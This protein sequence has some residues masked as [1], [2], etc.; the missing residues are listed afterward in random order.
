MVLRARAEEPTPS[1]RQGPFTAVFGGQLIAGRNVETLVEAADL[2]QDVTDEI[3]VVIA[4]AGPA[5]PLE[6]R[7]A[8]LGLSNVELT[9][10]LPRAAYGE[11]LRSAHLGISTNTGG[12]DV[13]PSRRRSVSTAVTV[14]PWSS[15]LRRH[16]TWGTSSPSRAPASRCRQVTPPALAAAILELWRRWQSD[17]LADMEAAAWRTFH[18]HLSSEV[19]ATKLVAAVRDLDAGQGAR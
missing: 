4:G 11:L 6:S 9:G 3:R 8:R 15:P 18:D 7:V 19:A 14:V 10:A 16:R 1:P 13:P 2:I 12:I 5:R 17:G